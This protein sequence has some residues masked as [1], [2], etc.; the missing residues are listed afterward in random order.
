MVVAIMDVAAEAMSGGSAKCTSMHDLLAAMS[1]EVIAVSVASAGL[2]P[3]YLHPAASAAVGA[4]PGTEPA[5]L[6]RPL[7]V[8][9]EK[10]VAIA[11]ERHAQPYPLPPLARLPDAVRRLYG[12][13]D[14][15]GGTLLIEMLQANAMDEASVRAVNRHLLVLPE[16]APA[17][18]EGQVPERGANLRSLSLSQSA[19]LGGAPRARELPRAEVL[20]AE[21]TRHSTCY[22]VL[23][24]SQRFELI[25][26]N[27]AH[28]HAYA[29]T[30]SKDGNGNGGVGVGSGVGCCQQDS[31]PCS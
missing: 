14:R 13:M 9:L 5:S 8:R 17:A 30:V 20:P 2:L 23:P 16:L 18:G 27:V 31:R 28:R 22:P 1:L 4:P 11:I 21:M 29:P 24:P 15:Y 25:N 7:R 26:V 12:A 6:E 10:L 19:V 3:H